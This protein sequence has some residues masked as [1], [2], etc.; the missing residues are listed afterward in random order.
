MEKSVPHVPATSEEYWSRVRGRLRAEFGDATFN[1][2]LK[3]L[4]LVSAGDERVVLTV[5][6]RFMRDWVVNRRV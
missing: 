1:S 5:P 3:P 6:T 4:M 2:W